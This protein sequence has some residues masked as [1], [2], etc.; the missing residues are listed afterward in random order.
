MKRINLLITALVCATFLSGCT[1]N[2]KHNIEVVE[3]LYG[4]AYVVNDDKFS[5][6]Q[7]ISWVSEDS[8]VAYVDENGNIVGNAPG[9]T[10][11]SVR[12]GD[13]TIYE[14]EVSVSV[15]PISEIVLSTNSLSMTVKESKT[16]KYILLPENASN[17]GITWMSADEQVAEVDENGTVVAKKVGQTTIV[18]SD[19]NG[20]ATKCNIVVNEQSAYDR[21]MLGHKELVDCVLEHL[22]EFKNP[23]SVEIKAVKPVDSGWYLSISAMNGFGGVSTDDFGLDR[24]SGFYSLNGLIDFEPD[25]LYN[26]YLDLINKAIEEKR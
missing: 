2:N 24:E 4:T 17:Y 23:D 22:N 14:Y 7:N 21:L 5:D 13:N 20:N 8:E 6:Y 16:L 18:V 26:S 15:N 25:I 10:L 12:D 3:L 9:K 11:V 19:T 1:D